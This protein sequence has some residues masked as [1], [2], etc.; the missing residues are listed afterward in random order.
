MVPWCSHTILIRRVTEEP[1]S[2]GLFAPANALKCG[3][4]FELFAAS[5]LCEPIFQDLLLR[6]L[7]GHKLDSHP[8]QSG[9]GYLP[10]RREYSASVSNPHPDLCA[11]GQ[12]TVR[13]DEAAKD[14]QVARARCDLPLRI[15]IDHVD[16][17]YKSVA[18]GAMLFQLHTQSMNPFFAGVCQVGT[19]LCPVLHASHGSGGRRNRSRAFRSTTS[20]AFAGLGPAPADGKRLLRTKFNASSNVAGDAG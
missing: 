9:I 3:T 2:I 20:L 4:G 15:D 16:P 12:G 11:A 8:R 19:A 18:H 5:K 13:L 17:G 1:C 7:N 14:A 10:Q 6:G